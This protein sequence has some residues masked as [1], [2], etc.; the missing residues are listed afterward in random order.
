[1]SS[2]SSQINGD[3]AAQRSCMTPRRKE[4]AVGSTAMVVGVALLTL[5]ILT[6]VGVFGGGNMYFVGTGMTV[7]SIPAFVVGIVALVPKKAPGSVQTMGNPDF[8][9]PRGVD[10]SSGILL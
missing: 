5:S 6:A 7:A 1:M 10:H 9:N 2:S 4:I 3:A 8:G